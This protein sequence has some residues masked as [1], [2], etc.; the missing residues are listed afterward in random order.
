MFIFNKYY[1]SFN[2]KIQPSLNTYYQNIHISYNYKNNII[3][4]VLFIFSLNFLYFFFTPLL[5]KGAFNNYTN[6]NS[7]LSFFISKKSSQKI[8]FN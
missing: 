6:F 5:Y 4:S 3:H 1:G 2:F 7:Y 8:F